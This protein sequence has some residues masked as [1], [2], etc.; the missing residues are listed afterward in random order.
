MTTVSFPFRPFAPLRARGHA[1][2]ERARAKGWDVPTLRD[3]R[4]PFAAILSLYGIL[5]FTFLG[6][7]RSATQML[8]IVATGA[9]LDAGLAWGL[10]RKR[11]VPLS[12]YISCCS[13]ALL[14]NYSHSSWVL[15]FPVLLTVGSKYVFT[16]EGRHVFNPSMF[17]IST[18]LLL[19]QELITAAPAYQWAGGS[20]TMSLFML[21][22][23]LTLFVLK[24]GRNWLVGSFLVF[25]ALQTAFRA[26][27]LRHHIPAEML[28]VGT[29]GSPPF[30]LF[31]F[32]MLTDPA[33]SPKTPKGQVLFAFVLTLVD[34]YLHVKESVFTFF[35][36]ALAMGT[37]KLLFLHGRA[38]VEGPG[39]YLRA[40]LTW[41]VLRP[42]AAIAVL[43]VLTVGSWF[44]VLRPA[45]AASVDPGFRMERLDGERTG[46]A[47]RM[48]D[49]FEQV[50]PRVQHVAK[51]ILSVGDAAAVGDV[52]GDGRL[53]LF[54]TNLLKHDD[55]RHA[56]YRN[57]SDFSSQ[58]A[59]SA[60]DL[61]FER[62]PLPAV[63]ARFG[64]RAYV[65]DGVGLPAGAT[66][67]DY[68]GD[69]DQDLAL[70][71][72]FGRSRLLQNRLVEDGALAF[73][74]VSEQVGLDEPS[75][76][77]AITFLDVDRDAR[78]DMVV[79]N[80]VDPYL[81]DYDPPR[82]LNL[83]ALPEAEHEGDRR[84]FHFMHDG[85]HDAANGGANLLYRGTGETFEQVDARAL[86]LRE[87]HW[88]LAVST[89]D[90]DHDGFTDLY[91]ASDFGPDDVY[92]SRPGAG[93][94]GRVFV[95]QEGPRFGTIGR[96]TYK[97]MNASV[98]DFD[99]NGFLD[100]YV[101]NVHHS[102]QAEG[103]LLW[104]VYPDEDSDTG[105]AFVDEATQRG[106]LNERRFGW[107]AGVGDLN[108]DGWFDIVQ[109]NGMVDDRLDAR[110]YER[111]DYWYVNHKLMQSGPEVHTYADMWGD[112]R[113]RVIYPNEARRAYLNL[114]ARGERF[115]SDVAAEIGI[116]DPDNSRGVV[117]A[118]LDDDGDL[119]LVIT[120]QHGPSSIYRNDLQQRPNAPSWVGLALEGDGARTHR[121]ALGTRVTLRYEENG[122]AVEQTAEVGVLGGFSAG[123][124][125]RLHFGLGRHH[126]PVEVTI[127]W[128]GAPSETLTLES[129]RY[130]AIRQ[131][132]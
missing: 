40:R 4:L 90:L 109:A 23:A 18:S 106:A 55:D 49:L 69:G 75:V 89:A 124:D 5:G 83:F 85:W 60:A 56:L 59:G 107:G 123:R 1:L 95:R 94:F 118:D 15:L 82:E 80:S 20:V 29:L 24:V 53:D 52:D 88:S 79:T 28:I 43:F 98:A 65:N 66:F 76:S 62:V 47:V 119:D 21:M 104:M 70:A 77:L 27:F 46:L 99:R 36:A 50:D 64:D 14:L 111:K 25:Y 84:M 101:S 102:L 34:L 120:N 44:F 71:V 73:V 33:T 54:F 61:R 105:I 58:S 125:P 103:S 39:A 41:P 68:D 117:V 11:L 108:G 92:L 87:T 132:E 78:L 112:I 42:I 30:F 74:D 100:V 48:G 51:W 26:W 2:A 31:T 9:A 7:N 113:G 121:S 72:G 126:G 13:L 45:A 116:D 17:G 97:G 127:H 93:P 91:V 8:A 3:P 32:Y 81:R 19:T 10:R 122:E 38:F 12:A 128:L 129:G 86:G 110:D 63:D 114:G 67:V 131:A 130:H 6:F 96:D 16:F 37:G 57:V 22:A 35:Y 115:F